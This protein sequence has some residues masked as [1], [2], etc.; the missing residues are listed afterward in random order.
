M[1][2]YYVIW[3]T[4]WRGDVLMIKP[5]DRSNTHTFVS[6]AV[7]WWKLK[8]M[9]AQTLDVSSPNIGTYTCF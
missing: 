8:Y 3:S 9:V 1:I 2:V 6:K 7:N 4:Q 5:V